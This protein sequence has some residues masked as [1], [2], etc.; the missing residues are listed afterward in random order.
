MLK[1]PRI[2]LIMM[3]LLAGGGLL[4]SALIQV[5]PYHDMAHHSLP[6]S[7]DVHAAHSVNASMQESNL[8]SFASHHHAS[9]MSY[10]DCVDHCT[11]AVLS[12]FFEP[13]SA[14]THYWPL[15]ASRQQWP[16]HFLEPVTP[17]P[18]LSMFTVS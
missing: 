2:V 17:P 14:L 11:L 10:L 12:P 15:L 1:I 4:L 6:I 3:C 13:F 5:T 8:A 18:R 9:D 7:V 16:H